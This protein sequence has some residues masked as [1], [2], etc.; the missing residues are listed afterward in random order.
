MLGPT[1]FRS[2]FNALFRHLPAA[3]LKVT[4]GVD[5]QLGCRFARPRFSFCATPNCPFAPVSPAPCWADF[6]QML[7]VFQPLPVVR[8]PRPFDAS[9]WLFERKYDGFRALAYV[10]YRGS[11]QR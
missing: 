6:A 7:P 9:D 8:R 4:P 1:D 11:P 10:D 2:I 5:D 3:A